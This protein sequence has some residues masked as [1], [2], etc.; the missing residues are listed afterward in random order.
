MDWQKVS[1][2][3]YR[4]SVFTLWQ[5]PQNFGKLKKYCMNFLTAVCIA[6][7]FLSTELEKQDKNPLPLQT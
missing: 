3:Q 1:I 6:K 4:K 2:V 5:M 7:D